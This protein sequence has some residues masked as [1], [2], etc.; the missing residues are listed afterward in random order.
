MWM[1]DK[2]VLMAKKQEQVGYSE[3]EE[4]LCSEMKQLCRNHGLQIAKD[5]QVTADRERIRKSLWG[6]CS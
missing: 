6:P 5:S 2:S 1:I 3:T 4:E